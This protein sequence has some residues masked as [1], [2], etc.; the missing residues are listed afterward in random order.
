MALGFAG[1]F[2]IVFGLAG[3][4][5]RGI[6]TFLTPTVTILRTLPVVSIIL[7]ILIWVGY[8]KAPYIITFLMIFPVVYQAILEGI[9]HID[10]KLIEALKLEHDGINLLIIKDLYLPLI[11]PFL[12][13][14]FL[15]SIGLGIKVLVMSEFIAQTKNS[16]GQMI[17]LEKQNLHFHLVFAWTIILVIIVLLIEFAV[18]RS[19]N[20]NRLF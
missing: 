8:E 20:T 14:A 19:K 9:R 5:N 10:V 18:V 3:G 6:A 7:V 16:I 4:L 13:T 11:T 1:F 17:Y 2:G 12:K 15:Q